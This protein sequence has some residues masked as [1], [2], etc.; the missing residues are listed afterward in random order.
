M[1]AAMQL[2]NQVPVNE[3]EATEELNRLIAERNRS[4]MIEHGYSFT[5]ALPEETETY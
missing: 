4:N 2:V 1:E 3:P 5:G